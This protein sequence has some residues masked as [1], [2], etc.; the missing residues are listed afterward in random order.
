MIRILAVVLADCIALSGGNGRSRLPAP[1]VS[2]ITEERN[3]RGDAPGDTIATDLLSRS[4]CRVV[5]WAE[6]G[7]DLFVL[8]HGS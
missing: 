6:G 4:S 5:G 8:R 2:S 1:D 3:P 7:G